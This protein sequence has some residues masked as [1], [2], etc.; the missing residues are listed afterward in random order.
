MSLWRYRV[1]GS[2]TEI[3]HLQLA[4]LRM[5]LWL[6]LLHSGLAM[7]CPYVHIVMILNRS[8]PSNSRR[9]CIRRH[10]VQPWPAVEALVGMTGSEK[11]PCYGLCH[12]RFQWRTLAPPHAVLYTAKS[13]GELDVLT[14]L[15]S[16]PRA[17]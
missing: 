6:S 13:L 1:H 8:R 9:G 14:M 7:I 11:L 15:T 12:F 5:D 17:H 16:I 2:V 3:A 10:P 4:T